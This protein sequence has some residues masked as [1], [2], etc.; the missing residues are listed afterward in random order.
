M[1]GRIFLINAI[2]IVVYLG[3][4]LLSAKI[5]KSVRSNIAV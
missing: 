5:Y 3:I 4:L 2:L 1:E